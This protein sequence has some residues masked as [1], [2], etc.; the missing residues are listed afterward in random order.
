MRLSDA[1]SGLNAALE[2]S[3]LAGRSDYSEYTISGT[4]TYGFALT[5]DNG[6][7]MGIVKPFIACNLNEY[8]NQR[9]RTGFGF[10]TGPLTSEL[11]LSHMM[12]FANDDD[13]TDSSMIEISMSLQF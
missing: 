6:Q 1:I 3:Y 4:V 5:D 9:V 12:S 7:E 8:G 13:D 11:A 10:D 2:G